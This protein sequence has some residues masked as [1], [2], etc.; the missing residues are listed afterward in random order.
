MDIFCRIVS[1]FFKDN[2]VNANSIEK[3]FE[4]V[5]KYEF[6]C[7]E[8]LTALIYLS[9]YNSSNFQL[10]IIDLCNIGGIIYAILKTYSTPNKIITSMFLFSKILRDYCFNANFIPNYN[11]YMAMYNAITASLEQLSLLFRS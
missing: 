1:R 9:K 2:T 5:T 4:L 10:A 3:T 6:P 7:K 11:I 8:T